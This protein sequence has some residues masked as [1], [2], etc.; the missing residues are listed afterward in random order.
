MPL[1]AD[2]IAVFRVARQCQPVF[3]AQFNGVFI[4]VIHFMFLAVNAFDK[5]PAFRIERFIFI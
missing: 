4:N 1:F 2:L 3:I 5:E